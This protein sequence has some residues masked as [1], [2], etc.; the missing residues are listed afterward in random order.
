MINLEPTQCKPHK[1]VVLPSWKD[2]EK[3]REIVTCFFYGRRVKKKIKKIK[4]KHFWPFYW[5]AQVLQEN[6]YLHLYLWLITKLLSLFL[7]VSNYEEGD[8]DLKGRFRL[9]STA[10]N[11]KHKSLLP[12]IT[13]GYDW[14]GH[15]RSMK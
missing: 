3:F 13:S 4:N 6:K 9:C 8:K 15:R 5:G 1:V 10:L 14:K 12:T 7:F 2:L 11:L